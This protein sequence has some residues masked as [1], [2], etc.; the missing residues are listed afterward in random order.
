MTITTSGNFELYIILDGIMTTL[1]FL[2]TRNKVSRSRMI[3][4]LNQMYVLGIISRLFLYV[5]V[6]FNMYVGVILVI[7]KIQNAVIQTMRMDVLRDDICKERDVFLKYALSKY[8]FK[9]LKN[10]DEELIS[11]KNYNMFMIYNYVTLHNTYR[12]IKV[13]LLLKLLYVLRQF[14]S[15]YYYY[16]AIKLAYYY[17]TGYLFNMMTRTDAVYILNIIFKEQRWFD[18]MKT[19]VIHSIYYLCIGFSDVSDIWTILFLHM[20]QFNA[21]WSIVSLVKYM[22]EINSSLTSAVICMLMVYK[23]LY[24][25]TVMYGVFMAFQMSS[26]QITMIYYIRDFI[27]IF[28]K[29]LWFYVRNYKDIKKVIEY[30]KRENSEYVIVDNGAFKNALEDKSGKFERKFAFIFSR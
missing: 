24:T 3:E 1:Q 5:L 16:K 6:S 21:V 9:N 20:Y 8:I 13:C 2:L 22:Y 23:K 17:N 7:P 4:D 18:L 27:I 30:Y 26:L 25:Y 14:E 29:E 15:T 28:S 12:V 11:I 10:L 19:D